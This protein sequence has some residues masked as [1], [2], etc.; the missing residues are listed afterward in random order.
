MNYYYI[1]DVE[2]KANK[3]IIYHDVWPKNSIPKRAAKGAEHVATFT[4]IAGAESTV[5][6]KRLFKITDFEKWI[7][8]ETHN[9][10]PDSWADMCWNVKLTL[11]SPE[12]YS[13]M[14]A[15]Y[16]EG[17]SDKPDAENWYI[18]TDIDL[19]PNKQKEYHKYWQQEGRKEAEAI[20]L[21]H[22]ATFTVISGPES[23]VHVKRLYKITD[24]EK[25]VNG[26]RNHVHSDKWAELAYEAKSTLVAPEP[27]SHF[28]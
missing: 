12:D 28:R 16:E 15:F 19:K 5:H 10:R 26:E 22:V 21:A 7:K 9:Y 8:G 27:Y 18:W 4:V 2:L 1:A 11:L 25:W 13:E 20:G 23:N 17:W 3:Q 24:L 14:E 6:V